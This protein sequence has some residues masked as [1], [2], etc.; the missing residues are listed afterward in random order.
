MDENAP[1]SQKHGKRRK[2]LRSRFKRTKNDERR[3]QGAL[4]EE[5]RVLQ[6]ISTNMQQA[7]AALFLESLKI[8]AAP[9]WTLSGSEQEVALQ[10]CILKFNQLYLVQSL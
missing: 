3:L 1:P 8:V 10:F 2:P 6:P 9:D 4:R 5:Q 7:P